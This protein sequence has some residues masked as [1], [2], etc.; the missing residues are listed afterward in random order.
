MLVVLEKQLPGELSSANVEFILE[1]ETNGK[2]KTV[3]KYFPLIGE[4][5]L[6]PTHRL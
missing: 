4:R 6:S 3:E 5:Q 1:E 2:A